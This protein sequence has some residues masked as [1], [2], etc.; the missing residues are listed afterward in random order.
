M[1]N[2]KGRDT[3][4]MLQKTKMILKHI[5]AVGKKL[6]PMVEVKLS[7]KMEILT[8]ETFSMVFDQVLDCTSSVVVSD[9]KEIGKIIISMEMVS[10]FAMENYFFKV[11]FK[12]V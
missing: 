3:Y 9:T 2:F 7:I 12:M 1:A 4:N 6:Y 11:N 5:K 10:Y 8:K